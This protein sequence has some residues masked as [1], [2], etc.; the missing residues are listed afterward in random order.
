L[1]CVRIWR[2]RTKLP[3][4]HPSKGEF[5]RFLPIVLL[6]FITLLGSSSVVANENQEELIIEIREVE[7][8]NE[9][10]N[11]QGQVIAE[12]IDM[13]G[14]SD[15]IAV[16]DQLIAIGTKVWDI[17][18]SGKPNVELSWVKPISVL[19]TAGADQTDAF[20]Q[21]EGW[22]MPVVKTFIVEAKNILGQVR[23]SFKYN[24]VYQHS[25]HVGGKGRYITG[26]FVNAREVIGKWG[27]SLSASSELMSISNIGSLNEPVAMVL[28]RLE[29]TYSSAF[30]RIK[31]SRLFTINGEGDFV[32]LQ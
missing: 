24:I 5:M 1:V 31:N 15:A 25:G 12:Y 4:K 30:K 26:L 29:Y 18:V 17:I 19:S 16:A 28:M 22:S 8:S 10:L 11:M 3:L 32:K 13:S 7:P 14:V 21:M 27:N 2:G 20:Y 9:T 23:G 6:F